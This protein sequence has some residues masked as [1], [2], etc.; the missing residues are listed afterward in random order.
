MRIGASSD[1]QSTWIHLCSRT[2]YVYSKEERFVKHDLRKAKSV[3]FVQ[4]SEK[5]LDAF[6]EGPPVVIDMPN[7]R[8]LYI[9]SD[10]RRETEAWLSVIQKVLMDVTNTLS[11]QPLSSDDIPLTVEKCTNFVATYGLQVEG[12]YRLSGQHSKVNRLLEQL[13]DCR[14]YVIKL[15]EYEV[16]DVSAALRRFIRNLSE[17]LL[18][19]RLRTRWIEAASSAD[20]GV[21]CQFY[22]YVLGELPPINYST[23]KRIITHLARVAEFESVNKMSVINLASIFGPVLM[24]VDMPD[25]KE[26][27]AA[28]GF[29]Q[30][31]REI[32]V[33]KDLIDNHRWL[34][35]VKDEELENERKME[36]AAKR[37]EQLNSRRHSHRS[38]SMVQDELLLIGV[39]IDSY[40]GDVISLQISNN[41][42]AHEL[43]SYVVDKAKLDANSACWAIF[44]II[45]EQQL[46]RPLHSMEIVTNVTTKWISWPSEFCRGAYLCVKHNYVYEGIID[47][48]NPQMSLFC[49]LRYAEKKGY[50]RYSFEFSKYMLSYRSNSKAAVPTASWNIEDLVVYV[51]MQHLRNPPTKWGFTFF[52]LTDN[53]VS[54]YF[55]HSVCCSS[56]QE[57][58]RWLAAMLHAQHP[59]GLMPNGP[60]GPHVV[61]KNQAAASATHQPS[62]DE[63]KSGRQRWKIVNKFTRK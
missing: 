12:I 23:L 47:V 63:Q 26:Q 36:E 38:V 40:D 9:Q 4:Q 7:G 14:S 30:T 32:C 56:E 13:A 2:L 42:R 50:R 34:F 60:N 55:G 19:D 49:E 39:H 61:Q 8:A 16:H 28:M 44:E 25:D 10:T 45:C 20:E 35:G 17:P 41:M 18:T 6:D 31:S 3:A 51:G 22:K 48:A 5:C 62:V 57:L 15:D 27:T 43:L 29:D 46:E 59:E 33:V 54:P 21:K 1:W 53:L 52:A 58:H 24:N 37:I 11:N